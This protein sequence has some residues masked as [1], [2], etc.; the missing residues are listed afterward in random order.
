M[1]LLETLLNYRVTGMAS[2]TVQFICQLSYVALFAYTLRM[3][4]I[5]CGRQGDLSQMMRQ[6]RQRLAQWLP[7]GHTRRRRV[8]RSTAA[9]E[10]ARAE[11]EEKRRRRLSSPRRSD[12]APHE[13]ARTRRGRCVRPP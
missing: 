4:D 11:T 13:T 12:S 6:A 8:R 3:R 5:I 7:L 1:S 10:R 2:L 9:H